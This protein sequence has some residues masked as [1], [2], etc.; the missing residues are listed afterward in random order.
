MLEFSSTGNKRKGKGVGR[1]L[2]GKRPATPRLKGR[3][4]LQATSWEEC[5]WVY[6]ALNTYQCFEARANWDS[7]W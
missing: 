4:S 6:V 7:K 1:E 2:P 5:Y 3:S